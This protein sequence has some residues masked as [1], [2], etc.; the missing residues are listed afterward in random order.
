MVS[1]NELKKLVEQHKKIEYDRFEKLLK[2]VPE[3]V[4]IVMDDM[5]AVMR[6]NAAQGYIHCLW[7]FTECQRLKLPAEAAC[8]RNEIMKDVIKQLKDAGF[9]VSTSDDNGREWKIGW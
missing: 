5:E 2:R 3:F 7:S 4:E 1:V 6:V 8:I 9:N